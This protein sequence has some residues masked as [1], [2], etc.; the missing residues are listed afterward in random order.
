[1]SEDKSDESRP[2]KLKQE[3]LYSLMQ[4][5][6]GPEQAPILKPVFGLV[7][8]AIEATFRHM[9]YTGPHLFV[10]LY[11]FCG[12]ELKNPGVYFQG[13]NTLA[14]ACGYSKEF[15]PTRKEYY[16]ALLYC[17]IS[18]AVS[19]VNQDRGLFDVADEDEAWR[20]TYD[21]ALKIMALNEP[22]GTGG[23]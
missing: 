17:V 2:Q 23:I 16:D 21:T 10:V 13:L 12:P 15:Y 19:F 18:Y 5:P 20:I 8:K 6:V 11:P 1:M 14:L 9:K 7:S 22:W 4:V 3:K